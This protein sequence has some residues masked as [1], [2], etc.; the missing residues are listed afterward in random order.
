MP[1]S[2]RTCRRRSVRSAVVVQILVSAQEQ[3]P[4]SANKTVIVANAWRPS[5]GKVRPEPNGNE[6]WT[7][8]N[9]SATRSVLQ[10]LR[11]EGYTWV[12]LQSGGTSKPF[13]DVAISR[14]I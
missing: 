11:D 6:G 14:L 2:A 1:L 9:E 4:P 10:R 7:H 12:N 3:F 8:L 5:D 13:R